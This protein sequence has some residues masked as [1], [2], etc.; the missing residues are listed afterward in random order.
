MRP[1]DRWINYLNQIRCLLDTLIL[2]LY[3][4]HSV[5]NVCYGELTDVLAK[6]YSLTAIMIQR[7]NEVYGTPSMWELDILAVQPWCV[8]KVNSNVSGMLWSYKYDPTL[9]QLVRHCVH[10][11][12]QHLGWLFSSDF[13][14]KINLNISR[15]LWSCKYYL[16]EKI[17]TFRGD[18]TSMLAK[19]KSPLF[20]FAD[21]SDDLD[22]HGTHVAGILAGQPLNSVSSV[23]Q[24]GIAP[25]ARL[26]FMDLGTRSMRHEIAS[27]GN[28]YSRCDDDFKHLL[29]YPVNRIAQPKK[30]ALL[31]FTNR[32][33]QD[34]NSLYSRCVL[35]VK[36]H[37][38]NPVRLNHSYWQGWFLASFTFAGGWI[39]NVYIY[40]LYIMHV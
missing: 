20:R 25:A 10:L 4:S 21:S 22:G 8:F 39:Y 14:F 34:Q 11:K 38:D 16:I 1:H 24:Q 7:W 2:K 12:T 6:I 18:L 17:N 28:L 15:I 31:S 3:F 33:L 9:E 37:G 27:P 29:F 36:S 30:H 40:T 13:V 5:I 19:T 32:I 23:S 26:A 35:L